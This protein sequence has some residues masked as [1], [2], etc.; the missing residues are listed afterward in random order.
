MS[1]ADTPIQRTEQVLI[2]D[3]P[4]PAP[5]LAPGTTP[6][7]E[8]F[9]ALK[10]AYLDNYNTDKP[11]IEGFIERRGASNKDAQLAKLS[12]EKAV[13]DNTTLNE[14]YEEQ[15]IGD[16]E[17]FATT[18]P[19]VIGIQDENAVLANKPTAQFVDS[20]AGP[21]AEEETQLAVAN[22][23]K[24]W[25]IVEASTADLTTLDY[26]ID[27]LAN[28][29][30]FVSTA[31]EGFTLSSVVNNID[32]VQE[33][34]FNFKNSSFEDQQAMFPLLAQEF[35]DGLGPLRGKDALAK[36]INPIGGE[37]LGDFSN[38]WKLF[39]VVDMV[40]LGTSGALSLARIKNGFNLPKVLKQAENPNGAG[41][42]VV[43]AL[44]DEE[45]AT[46]MNMQQDTAF[47]DAVAFDTS[48]VDIG[49]T[50]NLSTES[51]SSID[52]FFG[53]ADK[54][55]E[56]I[57]S[58]NGF[59]KEGVLNSVERA[60][61]EKIAFTK[62]TNAKHENI[63]LSERTEGS[64]S[65]TYQVKDE[66]GNLSDESFKLDFT[67][68]DVG[69]WNQSEIGVLSEWIAS[70]TV[71]AKGLTKLDARTAQR[72]DSQTA[73]VFR[74]LS[75]LQRLAVKPLG[76][77]L[78]PKNKKRLIEV[79]SVLRKG[80]EF[81]NADGTRGTVFDVDDLVGE[82]DFDAGQIV[83]YYNT[84]RLYNNLWRLRNSTKR[85]EMI[86]FGFKRVDLLDQEYSFGKPF[87]TDGD[88][89][90]A[91]RNN[92][93]T[94]VFDAT[95]DITV[96]TL[97]KAYL[98]EQ[99]AL[100]KTLVRLEDGYSIGGGRGKVKHVLVHTDSVGELPAVVVNRKKGYVPKVADDGFWFVKEYG[101]EIVDGV[102][103]NGPLKTLRYFDNKKE[104]VDFQESE[105]AKAME[106][107][108][109]LTRIQAE[110][111]FKAL[112][113]REQEINATAAGNFSH[114]SG[115]V[116]TGV[117]A[118]DDILFGM[119]GDKGQRINPYEALTRNIGSVSRLVPINQWRLGLEQRWINT[120]RNLTGE[121]ITS[122][123][124]LPESIESNRSGVFLNKMAKQIRDWQG[125]P[126]KEEQVYNAI[127]QRMYEWS[128]KYD[129]KRS[130]KVIGWMR[131]KDP[132]AASRAAAFHSLLGWYNPAQLWVQAQ[133]MSVAVSINLGKNLTETLRHTTG[134]TVL[135]SNA[136]KGSQ[137]SKA[138]KVAGV[139]AKEM[140]E[141]YDLWKKTGLEDSI[142]QTADHA[143][144]LRGHGIAMDALSRAADKGLFFYR[145]GELL[146][147]RMSFTTAL[148]EWK[149]A[150]KGMSVSDDALK[151]IVDR[152]NN[153]MLNM[154]K[155][156]A[157]Q[158]QKGILSL[159]TQ[160]WQVSAKALETM[161]GFND[162]LKAGERARVLAGQIALYGTAGIPLAGLAINYAIEYLG[163]TQKQ[164]DDNPVLVKALNDGFWG[165]I[166]MGIFDVDAE[167]SSRGSLVRGV[168]DFVD[169]WIY[170][171]STAGEKLLGAFG[172]TQQ[173]FWD[174]LTN[175]TK[176]ISLYGVPADGIDA[177]KLVTLPFLDSISTWRNAEKAVFMQL[178][179]K[180]YDKHLDPTVQRPFE[181]RESVV[182]A[183]GFRL[184]DEVQ[185]YNL[186]ERTQHVIDTNRRHADM[187][188]DI[189]EELIL[190][191]AAGTLTPEYEDQAAQMKSIL[192]NSLEFDR[193]GEVRELYRG[194]IGKQS[195]QARAIDKYTRKVKGDTVAGLSD[196]KA[197]I[198][199]TSIQIVN[200]PQEEE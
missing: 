180:I 193:R 1:I 130:A 105:I 43:T 90:N 149:T 71:F 57:M 12:A 89:A 102:A 176:K 41:D 73:K 33:M 165:V 72:L 99:Y 92:N 49:H 163:V 80:D 138:A 167:V 35:L 31:R 121:D 69:Q 141:M 29:V 195:K 120:A 170:A 81:K 8:D 61:R 42:T 91:I 76:S 21:T 98:E 74:Q 51:L 128:L 137:F 24:L 45:A 78:R 100:G 116:Y 26:S 27:F 162:N 50:E 25:E 86:A 164:I 9:K 75:D 94:Q 38:W 14:V 67:L 68:N 103:V 191:D 46:A 186:N 6:A 65:F 111:K 152:A 16:P 129:M 156:N 122:F 104:A 40:S 118:E 173:R 192:Y 124:A 197:A 5:V 140:Q 53:K 18:A 37:E 3:T 2:Q 56:Q 160:F 77:L 96:N 108:G 110:G 153:L 114:G 134:L 189:N 188:M 59:L 126:S 15:L 11:V 171:D 200:P 117:R 106:G 36:F 151:G 115:G 113:D 52:T 60:A 101:D 172:S 112:E 125:F 79:E 139:D 70:P 22:Y 20:I 34:I 28:I 17:I 55:V 135:G 142:L 187:L 84:N 159:P 7:L 154:S 147:R 131:D 161:L 97:S 144:G 158:F 182:A 32:V 127:N 168:S 30:P 64:T 23:V 178:V 184:S 190:R 146:N 58:G 87:V 88:A 174:S 185:A 54:T 133:G 10:A 83:A 150:N 148:D 196:M 93:V 47:G 119:N 63:Q 181:L 169:N 198:T 136:S 66:A 194:K 107:E 145:H 155:A 177:L 62:L 44:A 179:D 175:Q 199:G 39:D 85:E 143:A 123:G 109:G 13:E 132:I 48:T 4:A 166:T 95:E 19:L 157:A 183:I 82:F